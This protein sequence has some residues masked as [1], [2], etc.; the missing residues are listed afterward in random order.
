MDVVGGT[1]LL[2]IKPY[3]PAFDDREEARIGWFAGKLRGVRD[4][5][6]DNRFS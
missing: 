3:V 5:R 6:A 2:D 1:P 4:A